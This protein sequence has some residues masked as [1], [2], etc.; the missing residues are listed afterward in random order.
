MRT[1]RHPTRLILLVLTLFLAAHV[2]VALGTEPGH[3]LWGTHLASNPDFGLKDIAL[4]ADG[5]VYVSSLSGQLYAVNP[6]GGLKWVYD[7]GPM[8]V[9]CPAIR[10]APY[11]EDKQYDGTIYVGMSNG[12]VLAISPAGQ[13][14]WTFQAGCTVSGAPAIARDGT[15][16][17]GSRSSALY[18]INP[19]GTLKWVFETIDIAGVE[20]PII[21]PDGTIYFGTFWE[22]RFY[23][24]NPD[25]SQKWTYKLTDPASTSPA[26]G[27]G[28]VLYLGSGW[29]LRA[30]YP[31]G[32]ARWVVPMYGQVDSSPAIGDDGTIYVA[33]SAALIAHDPDATEKWIFQ[34]DGDYPGAY[35]SSAAVDSN[36]TIYFGS[37]DEHLYAV[38]PDGSFHWDFAAHSQVHSSPIIGPDGTLYICTATHLVAFHTGSSGPAS[39]TWP[40]YRHDPER[41][42]RLDHLWIV[43]ASINQLIQQVSLL[44]LPAGITRSLVAK[45]ESA[46]QSVEIGRVNAAMFKLGAFVHQ[47]RALT[48]RRI[49]TREADALIREARSIMSELNDLTG[50]PHLPRHWG[51]AWK[52]IMRHRLCPVRWGVIIRRLSACR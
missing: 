6:G 3:T 50:R 30:F 1:R 42:G 52:R 33:G 22:N 39:S 23:A 21:G 31:W 44:R 20:D 25:G 18:A 51:I 49:P 46:L 35:I 13:L 32:G 11:G 36:G 14:V 45:L 10:R 15:I 16:Y 2:G 5:T 17:V 24:V 47:V 41:S 8:M 7:A 28:G 40:M 4:A 34:H 37:L 48:G 27:G 9:T 38:H 19:N 29:D 43:K 26:I 12:R